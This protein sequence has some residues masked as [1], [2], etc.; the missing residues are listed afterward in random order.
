[1]RIHACVYLVCMFPCVSVYPS[2]SRAGMLVFP[3]NRLLQCSCHL[4]LLGKAM[5]V[6]QQDVDQLETQ[7]ASMSLANPSSSSS[8]VGRS[9]SSY[10]SNKSVYA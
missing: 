2:V 3:T 10:P 5:E 8:G 7:F 1:M 9:A 4:G 6:D